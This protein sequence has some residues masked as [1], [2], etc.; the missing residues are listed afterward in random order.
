MSNVKIISNTH[1]S[2]VVE[3]G[4]GNIKK[5]IAEE[6][7]LRTSLIFEELLPKRQVIIKVNS[8]YY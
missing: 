1:E 7:L 6:I 8:Q 2:I 3:M 5:E 4:I